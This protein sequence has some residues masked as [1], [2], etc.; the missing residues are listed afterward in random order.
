MDREKNKRLVEEEEAEGPLESPQTCLVHDSNT[1][2]H[3]APVPPDNQLSHGPGQMPRHSCR[4]KFIIFK[5]VVQEGTEFICCT[6]ISARRFPWSAISRHTPEHR[7]RSKNE[8]S[9]PRL[10][11]AFRHFSQ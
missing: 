10:W 11:I 5:Q 4:V 2:G 1:K 9:M 3:D 6:L 7:P 8:K